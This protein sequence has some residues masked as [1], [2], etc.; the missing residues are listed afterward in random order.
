MPGEYVGASTAG[1]AGKEGQVMRSLI[2]YTLVLVGSISLLT[3]IG[4]WLSG[5]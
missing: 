3:Q 1:M 5:G 4:V 2:V